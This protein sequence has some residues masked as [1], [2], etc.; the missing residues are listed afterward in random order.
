MS[1]R[2]HHFLPALL[3]LLI[4]SWGTCPC[5]ISKAFADPSDAGDEVTVGCP[6]CCEQQAGEEEPKPGLPEECPCCAR[7]G[8]NR[9]LPP[10]Q[11]DL[12]VPPMSMDAELWFP[13][14]PTSSWVLPDVEAGRWEA[15]LPPS[16]LSLHG[17]PVGIVR[18]LN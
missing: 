9:P 5:V 6:C 15:P 7:S 4:L 13:E 18:L 1:R 17:C 14:L 3:C 10:V 2:P 8:A 11:A 12:V 16:D